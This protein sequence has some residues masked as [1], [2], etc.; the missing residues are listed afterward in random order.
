VLFGAFGKPVEA[1]VDAG[2]KGS[3]RSVST[4]Q[5]ASFSPAAS[6]SWSWLRHGGV[7]SQHAVKDLADVLGERG[8]D[9]RYAVHPSPAA[10]PAT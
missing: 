9:V 5:A 1:G 7:A 3:V 8:I 10:C 6:V 4:D 2:V